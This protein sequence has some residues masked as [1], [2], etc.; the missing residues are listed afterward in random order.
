[1]A[2]WQYSRPCEE[3]PEPDE[4][5]ALVG[6]EPATAKYTP[7]DGFEIPDRCGAMVTTSQ[8]LPQS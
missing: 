6:H 8:R 5:A 1:M 3:Q 4:V 7:V 2:L